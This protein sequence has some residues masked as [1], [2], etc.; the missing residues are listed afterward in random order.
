M[1]QYPCLELMEQRN[2]PDGLHPVVWAGSVGHEDTKRNH[3]GGRGNSKKHAPGAWGGVWREFFGDLQQLNWKLPYAFLLFTYW[4][5]SILSLL[6]MLPFAATTNAFSSACMPDGSFNIARDGY[7]I[8]S[9]TGFF[10]ITIGFGPLSFTE[11]KII[12]TC[13]DVVRI[14]KASHTI[15]LLTQ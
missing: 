10:Q 15:L 1:N 12:N 6:A 14:Y 9:L 4:L 5:I 11:A 3:D 8:W 2:T 13:W 7:N